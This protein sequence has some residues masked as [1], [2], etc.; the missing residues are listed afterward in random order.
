MALKKWMLI[1][2]L[3][4][5]ASPAWAGTYVS[6]R[7]C[8]Y[9]HFYG[10]SNCIWTSTYVPPPFPDFEQERADAI[11]QAKQD[12][13]WDT[14]CQPTFRTDQYGVRRASYAAKGCD[15]GRSE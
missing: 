15:V 3:V 1:V 13:K 14:F 10:Y 5:T 2:A 4:V 6:T 9:S 12:E 11:A 8:A 7:N